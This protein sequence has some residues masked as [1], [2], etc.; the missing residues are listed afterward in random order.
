MASV[1]EG[2]HQLLNDLNSGSL[3]LSDACKTLASLLTPE[4]WP[5]MPLMAAVEQ[6]AAAAVLERLQSLAYPRS[7]L[8]FLSADVTRFVSRLKRFANDQQAAHRE[9]EQIRQGILAAAAEVAAAH[10]LAR[11]LASMLFGCP[12][13]TWQKELGADA[14]LLAS[15]IQ[16]F[17]LRQLY[18]VAAECIGLWD[19]VNVATQGAAHAAT[20]HG[21][22][23]GK[24]VRLQDLQAAVAESISPWVLQDLLKQA[25]EQEQQQQQLAQAVVD[26]LQLG[27]L[28]AAAAQHCCAAAAAATAAATELLTADEAA[29]DARVKADAGAQLLPQIQLQ[30]RKAAAAARSR[31]QPHLQGLR[32]DA[33]AAKAMAESAQQKAA[34]CARKAHQAALEHQAAQVAAAEARSA[35]AA[36]IAEVKRQQQL[37]HLLLQQQQQQ[38]GP[39][40]VLYTAVS[41]MAQHESLLSLIKAS[42][43]AALLS[44]HIAAIE[45]GQQ[46]LSCALAKL[47]LTVQFG[48][49]QHCRTVAQQ[50]VSLVDA[51]GRHRAAAD[52]KASELHERLQ[53]GLVQLGA[54]GALPCNRQASLSSTALKHAK[55][56]REHWEGWVRQLGLSRQS[57][58]LPYWAAQQSCS[59]L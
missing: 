52:I 31:A 9:A 53:G 46:Q 36:A 20:S 43:K 48:L 12:P 27:A 42:K 55:E 32:T 16:R 54:G 57:S 13:D 17:E 4:L 28:S 38:L 49:Q 24:F 29:A 50:V 30:P 34:E 8:S 51:M 47:Q 14:D 6:D 39:V 23:T 1:A 19:A 35:T 2:L 59:T 7:K 21:W 45:A 11:C 3:R 26:M 33:E 25:Q 44:D 22:Q 41:P 40:A 10:E 15:C 18:Q 58:S 56:A 5:P 37:L